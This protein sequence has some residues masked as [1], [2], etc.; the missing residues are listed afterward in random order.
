MSHSPNSDGSVT[1]GDRCNFFDSQSGEFDL[2]RD[3]KDDSQPS[4]DSI[5][6]ADEEIDIT[7]IDEML[8]RGGAHDYVDGVNR[9][10][11]V[12]GTLLRSLGNP[13][14]FCP[15]CWWE[16]EAEHELSE[17]QHYLPSSEAVFSYDEENSR[18]IRDII[19]N[20]HRQHRH[21]PECGVVSFG[22]KLGD[23]PADAFAEVLD[24]ILSACKHISGSRIRR[25][26]SNAMHRK[27]KKGMSDTA[28]VEQMLHEI[29]FGAA[30][31]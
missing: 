3:P 1:L 17:P 20:D 19:R 7:P 15:E 13:P 6:D 24:Q 30:D 16:F 5:D 18:L 29:R 11:F 4:H 9:D 2:S 23:R 31:N 25:L 14:I 21:C 22:G 28:N 8:D 12:A 27:R 10:A 26:R